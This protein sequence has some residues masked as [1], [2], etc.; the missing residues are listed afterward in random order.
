[1]IIHSFPWYTAL[2]L[3]ACVVA[4]LVAPRW[5]RWV[6]ALRGAAD[7][8]RWALA[9]IQWELTRW[10]QWLRAVATLLWAFKRHPRQAWFV[11][12]LWL[13]VAPWRADRGQQT[14]WL[15]RVCEALAGRP[16]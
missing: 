2:T 5:A 15:V 4:C 6:A 13:H 11:L 16:E 1:M 9:D 12:T 10:A 8:L 7:W 14:D 3:A